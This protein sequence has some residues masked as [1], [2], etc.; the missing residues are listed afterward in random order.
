[1]GATRPRNPEAGIVVNDY[2]VHAPGQVGGA[3]RRASETAPDVQLPAPVA[4]D[5]W[6]RPAGRPSGSPRP[7]RS[8]ATT[9]NGSCAL[10]SGRCCG[11]A[12]SPPRAVT[13]C[14]RS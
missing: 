6:P 7:S 1:V 4:G 8:P 13:T 9:R 14:R 2:R 5:P 10:P 11:T 3:Y 12:I